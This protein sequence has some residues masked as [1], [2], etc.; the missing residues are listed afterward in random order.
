MYTLW[1]IEFNSNTMPASVR[2]A[3]DVHSKRCETAKQQRS[4]GGL[5]TRDLSIDYG[6]PRSPTIMPYIRL[7]ELAI[8]THLLLTIYYLIASHYVSTDL[9]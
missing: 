9:L 6:L 8:F 3:L 7:N 4:G 2:L 1:G 5:M